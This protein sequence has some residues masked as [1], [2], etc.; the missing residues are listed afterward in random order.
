MQIKDQLRKLPDA[1]L[2]KNLETLSLR[3][4]EV[5]LEILL[6]LIELENRKLHLTLW[7]CLTLCL[8][9]W[10]ATLLRGRGQQKN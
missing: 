10:Q 4:N 8:L 3:E 2:I 5:T 9:P 1:T 7:V 6:Q